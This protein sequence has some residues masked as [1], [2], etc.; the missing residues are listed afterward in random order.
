MGRSSRIPESMFH[1]E[2]GVLSLFVQ[3]AD[4]SWQEIEPESVRPLVCR[5]EKRTRRAAIRSAGIPHDP[6]P[7]VES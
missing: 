5:T 3:A 6:G 4:G 2:G 7:G 1:P